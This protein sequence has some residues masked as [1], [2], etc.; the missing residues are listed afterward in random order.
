MNAIEDQI[1]WEELKR[2]LKEKYPQLKEKDFNHNLLM[3]ESTLRMIE[4][5]LHK[6]KSEMKDVIGKITTITTK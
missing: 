3:D 4:Y 6:T 2:K 5:K 1:Y